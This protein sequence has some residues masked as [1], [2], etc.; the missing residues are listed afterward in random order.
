MWCG[1]ISA[2]SAVG[3]LSLICAIASH[4]G[5][6]ERPSA[7]A[8]AGNR[9]RLVVQLG[10][11]GEVSLQLHF[12]PTASKLTGSFDRT[13]RLWD[14][15]TGNRAGHCKFE[16]H[17]E[18][19]DCVAISPD[20]QQVLTGGGDGTAADCGMRPAAGRIRKFTGPTAAVLSVAF[21]HG[22]QTTRKRGGKSNY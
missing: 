9:P 2:I 14:I 19:V 11:E 5:G 1:R 15:A 8:A 21:F 10:H 7:T 6:D 17:S 12:R 16:G 20:G 13:A 4:A 18:G 3:A 22:R